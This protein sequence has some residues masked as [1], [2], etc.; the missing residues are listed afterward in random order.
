MEPG[1]SRWLPAGKAA[2]AAIE[3]RRADPNNTEP[4]KISGFAG[5]HQHQHTHTQF[6][7]LPASQVLVCVGGNKCFS[8]CANRTKEIHL[9][10]VCWQFLLAIQFELTQ[11]IKCMCVDLICNRLQLVSLL[12]NRAADC[13]CCFEKALMMQSSPEGSL[14][15]CMDRIQSLSRPFFRAPYRSGDIQ[16]WSAIIRLQLCSAS[17]RVRS[18]ELTGRPAK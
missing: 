16:R 8:Y 17:A 10:F 1:L 9:R 18:L 2:A 11:T 12:S 5:A 15:I 7:W 4:G 14:R 6:N 13:R 3:M